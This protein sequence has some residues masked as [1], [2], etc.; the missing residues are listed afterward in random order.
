MSRVGLYGLNTSPGRTCPEKVVNLGPYRF[1]RLPFL[2]AP[3]V[4]DPAAPCVSICLLA[5]GIAVS[6]SCGAVE[7]LE[8][9]GV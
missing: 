7:S 6:G 3:D 1:W 9:E 5:N 2:F 8:R 4:A